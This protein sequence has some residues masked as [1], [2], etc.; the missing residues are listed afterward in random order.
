[1]PIIYFDSLSN[2]D[3]NHN[4]SQIKR[5]LLLTYLL[6]GVLH[7]FLTFPFSQPIYWLFAVPY[8]FLVSFLSFIS[9]FLYHILFPDSRK[10]LLTSLLASYP[11]ASQCRSQ[12]NSASISRSESVCKTYFPE[13]L[14]G[15]AATIV[16]SPLWLASLPNL[17]NF[18]T[19]V[20]EH[21]ASLIFFPLPSLI[22]PLRYWR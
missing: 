16:I 12:P 8:I 3:P 5:Y 19:S 9:S 2:M 11:R 13:P 1:M 10:L 14:A 20:I 21:W 4:N 17:N 18:R 7:I 15:D 6:Q 22:F